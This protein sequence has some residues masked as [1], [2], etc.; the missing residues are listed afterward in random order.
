MEAQAPM[1]TLQFLPMISDGEGL[2]PTFEHL[3]LRY[4]DSID[5]E[6]RQIAQRDLRNHILPR[7]GQLRS[8]RV[9]QADISSW[10]TAKVEEEDHPQEWTAACTRS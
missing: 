5:P 3:A 2:H 8:T 6:I 1:T 4:L 9:S 10:L 7:F